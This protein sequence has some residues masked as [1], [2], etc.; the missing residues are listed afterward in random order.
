MSKNARSKALDLSALKPDIVIPSSVRRVVEYTPN[1]GKQTLAHVIPVEI[2]LYG[3]AR[4]GG[5]SLFLLMQSFRDWDKDG[6][7]ALIIRRNYTELE[8]H[9]IPESKRMFRDVGAYNEKTHRWSFRTPDGGESNLE[10]GYLESP[11]DLDAYQGSQ[12]ARISFDE[13]TMFSEY[14]IR[15]LYAC[16]RSPLKDVRRQLLLTCNPIGPGLGWHKKM[17]HVEDRSCRIYLDARWPSDNEAV[18]AP[19]AFIPSRVWD[20]PALLKND[21]AYPQRLRSQYGPVAEAML[22]GSW[23]H[24]INL[25]LAFDPEPGGAHVEPSPEFPPGTFRWMAVD[26]GKGDK[27][28]TCWF[29]EYH[30]RVYIYRNFSVPGGLIV[31]YA[32]TILSMTSEREE[33]RFC[34][35]SHECFAERGAMNTLAD[36]FSTAFAERGIPVQNSGRDPAGRL[37]LLRE[38]L[39]TAPL[40]GE[41]LQ[42]DYKYWLEKLRTG[43]R[44]AERELKAMQRMAHSSSLPRLKIDP[45]CDGIIRTWPNL[46]VDQLN[47]NVLA[48]GQD[49]HDFDSATYGLKW[50]VTHSNFEERD[51]QQAI[52]GSQVPESPF[53][54]DAALREARR[55]L[56]SEPSVLNPVEWQKRLARRYRF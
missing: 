42:G 29:A 54:V 48:N 10:F 26:W 23:E 36:Q 39:R 37:M 19:I 2:L 50:H 3:G 1:P 40:S 30:G 4:G 44:E 21:P 32:Q 38:Y 43:G 22:E 24:S 17:F 20:N 49:D 18:G 46:V 34:V 15:A 47:P 51:V 28:S 8:R 13:S 35:L 16:L 41:A 45:S 6:Y 31:P 33:V 55:L 27:A 14:E 7:K 53:Q 5:K 56:G 9:I 52:L 25:A 12:F 11:S